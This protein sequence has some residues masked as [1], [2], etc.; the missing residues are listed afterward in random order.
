[1]TTLASGCD[2]SL[3]RRQGMEVNLGD[4]CVAKEKASSSASLLV[5]WKTLGD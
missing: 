3:W 1:M 4:C 2:V 5:L